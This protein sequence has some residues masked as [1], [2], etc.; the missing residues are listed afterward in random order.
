[1][2]L[3]GSKLCCG[4]LMICVLFLQL[5]QIFKATFRVNSHNRHEVWQTVPLFIWQRFCS[6]SNL[7]GHVLNLS[8][9]ALGDEHFGLH[10][11]LQMTSVCT[12]IVIR[13]FFAGVRDC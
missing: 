8:P 13:N 3:D 1:M 10:I 6:Y 12:D 4:V 11:R 5:G 7:L 9:L 2:L